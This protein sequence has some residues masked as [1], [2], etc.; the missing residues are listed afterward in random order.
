MAPLKSDSPLARC[1]GLF[2]TAFLHLG[3]MCPAGCCDHLEPAPVL[4]AGAGYPCYA[5]GPDAPLWKG[6]DGGQT[7][8]ELPGGRNLE[9]LAVRPTDPQRVH[10]HV[11]FGEPHAFWGSADGGRTG[12][13]STVGLESVVYDPGGPITQTYGL[14][15]LAY[16]PG[17]LDG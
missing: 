17:D 10:A 7:W 6:L 3:K 16:T 1:S 11:Y 15:D 4:Y 9:P 13:T 2:A 5:G 12:F 8:F 14:L